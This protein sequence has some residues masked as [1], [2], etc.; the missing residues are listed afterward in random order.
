MYEL[1]NILPKLMV[2]LDAPVSLKKLCHRF[3]VIV[4]MCIENGVCTTIEDTGSRGGI[5]FF[6]H[7]RI[8]HHH[9]HVVVA[10][11]IAVV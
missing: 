6:L 5:L 4:Q 10:A 2:Y 8:S 1:M 7:R 3:F 9:H 11:A